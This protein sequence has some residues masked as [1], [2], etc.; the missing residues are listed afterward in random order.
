MLGRKKVAFHENHFAENAGM[1][2]F[3]LGALLGLWYLV[4][5]VINW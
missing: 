5:T 1:F 2:I 4:T 3:T